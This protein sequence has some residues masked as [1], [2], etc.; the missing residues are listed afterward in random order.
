MPFAKFH[1]LPSMEAAWN[2][3][4][5][6]LMAALHDNTTVHVVTILVKIL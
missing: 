5:T 1:D 6:T 3:I 4:D 2:L